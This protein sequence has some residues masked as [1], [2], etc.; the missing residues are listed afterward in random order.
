M[1]RQCEWR[2]KHWDGKQKT[3]RKAEFQGARGRVVALNHVLCTSI[4]WTAKSAAIGDCDLSVKIHFDFFY[5]LDEAA[6][7][8]RHHKVVVVPLSNLQQ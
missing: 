4:R 8:A 7:S 3:L 1:S 2:L 6:I 5:A